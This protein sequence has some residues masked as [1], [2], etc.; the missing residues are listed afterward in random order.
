MFFYF[1]AGPVLFLDYLC[2]NH[3]IIFFMV[4]NFFI[5]LCVMAYIAFVR[6]L[7]ELKL[8]IRTWL[9]EEVVLPSLSRSKSMKLF[10]FARIDSG[11]ISIV[12]PIS[13][14]LKLHYFILMTHDLLFCVLWWFEHIVQGQRFNH[15]FQTFISYS[16]LLTL[17]EV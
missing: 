7:I 3:V 9:R 6:V 17:M 16:Y 2:R 15:L 13:K 1:K 11:S 12:W 5:V 10:F 8:K 4:R 14:C